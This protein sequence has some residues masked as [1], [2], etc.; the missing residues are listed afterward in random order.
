[1][2]NNELTV[3]MLAADI[4]QL[5]LEVNNL[6]LTTSALVE[7]LS[8]DKAKLKDAAQQIYAAA[9]AHAQE[10]EKEEEEKASEDP[11]SSTNIESGG[12]SSHPENAVIF[13]GD[14]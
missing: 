6:A 14:D 5:A 12:P 8:I 3:D 11:L 9:I 7:I 13:G 1:M 2:E 10:E 4:R